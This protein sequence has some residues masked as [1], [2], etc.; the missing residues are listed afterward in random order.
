MQEIEDLEADLVEVVLVVKDERQDGQL[1]TALDEE[2]DD[3]VSFGRA[4]RR[5]DDPEHFHL[6]EQIL[7]LA[8]LVRHKGVRQL[9]QALVVDE[10]LG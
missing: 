2:C 6:Q 7:E 1:D 5:D 3:V 10:E 4:A 8:V 9:H